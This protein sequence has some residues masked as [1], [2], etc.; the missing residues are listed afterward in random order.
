MRG[1]IHRLTHYEQLS[2]DEAKKLLI[3]LSEGKFNT[4]SIA[5]LLTV[6]MMRP[7][8][9]D[10]LEGFR[11]ALQE[12]CLHVN[13]DHPQTIDVCGTGGDEKNTFNISTLTAF[14]LAGSG[15]SVTKHGN[16]SVSS[17]SGSSNVLEHF[18]VKFSND[19]D[20]LNRCLDQASICFLH[21]PLFHPAM[22]NVAPIRKDLKVK[23]FFNM[24]GPMI[25][26]A[27]PKHQLVGV[28]NLELM[29]M[30]GYLYQKSDINYTILHSL[31]GHDEI[32]L[33][34]DC[35]YIS[36]QKEGIFQ[37]DDFGV[38]YVTDLEII[39]GKTA[40]ESADT[41]YKILSSQGTEAQNNVVSANAGVALSMI[42][43]CSIKEGFE[44][45]KENLL[46]GNAKKSLETLI[47][48]SA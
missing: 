5:V 19:Q 45:A 44:T 10:E 31:S 11:D 41:F 15:I 13:L 34:S 14:V 46:N 42:K 36:N 26:P 40:E 35:K 12:L 4:H 9:L 29:R 37:A 33:T 47:R 28:F 39:G 38:N 18:G 17:V 22:K 24:L 16:Y 27:F 8:S 2:K 20:Q 7:I 48:L 30:Y 1:I 43:N 3:E 25:N 23:T 21:A 32:S 6:F